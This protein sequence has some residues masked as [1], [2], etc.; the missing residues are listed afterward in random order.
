MHAH[1][2]DSTAPHDQAGAA[3]AVAHGRDGIASHGIDRAA[4][5]RLQRLAGNRAV[6]GVVQR[7]QPTPAGGV[8]PPTAPVPPGAAVSPAEAAPVEL[9]QAGPARITFSSAPR[10]WQLAT[11]DLTALK[12]GKGS[13]STGPVPA[14]KWLSV[15]AEVGADAP[16][17]VA[18]TSLSILPINGEISASQVASARAPNTTAGAIGAAVG[19]I[20]GGGL[21]TP[22]L[23]AGPLGLPVVKWA[24]EQGGLAGGAVGEAVGGLFKGDTVLEAALT[25]GG[26]AG[27]I[28]FAYSPWFA[29][30]L[31]ATGFSWLADVEARLNTNLTLALTA[32]AKLAD[33]AKVRL[34]FRDGRLLHTAF[35]VPLT[36]ELSYI[37][38][39]MAQLIAGLTLLPVLDGSVFGA[40]DDP[41]LTREDKGVKAMEFVSAP[42]HLFDF[43]GGIRPFGVLDLAKGSPLE[44]RG[45][46]FGLP[47]QFVQNMLPMALGGGTLPTRKDRPDS[48]GKGPANPTGLTPEDPIPMTWFKP[49][50]MYPKAVTIPKDRKGNP[51]TIRMFPHR[52]VDGLDIGVDQYWP[53]VGRKIRKT[54]R[55]RGGGEKK[56]ARDLEAHGCEVVFPTVGK[57][58]QFDF[59]DI[60]HV[61]DLFWD[62]PDDETNLWPLERATNQLAGSR[63]LTQEVVW[64]LRKGGQARPTPLGAVPRNR[65]FVIR[66]FQDPR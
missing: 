20:V 57:R 30:K 53:Y 8:A 44:V 64:A 37:F 3:R 23:T 40:G 17:R 34:T 54:Q 38:D 19:G 1:E 31:S 39:A 60:D 22:A 12:I 5:P 26:V 33:T 58:R 45:S 42:F 56:F 9:P 63:N 52:E 46:K 27:E 24:A 13:L 48:G 18:K 59:T 49:L 28:L 36:L 32:A 43:R 6:A 62:G 50:D 21:A 11:P 51:I 29:L 10:T 65:W 41:N 16:L 66:D 14:G 4:M 2:H 7:F 35:S 55:P 25:S 61:L 47:D 15:A